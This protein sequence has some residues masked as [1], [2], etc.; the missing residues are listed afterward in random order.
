MERIGIAFYRNDINFMGKPVTFCVIG[1]GDRGRTYASYLADHPQDARLVA[2]AEPRA[3][4]RHDMAA[5]HNIPDQYIFKDWRQVASLEESIADAVI[6]TTQDAMHTTPAL[7][8]IDKGY[9]VLLEKPMAP[10]KQ[11]CQQIVQAAIAKKI[12]FSVCHVLRYTPYTQKIK[13]LLDQGAIGDVVSIQHL[14]PIGYDHF[15]H[16][17]V[18]GHWRNEKES[19][20]MLLAK[21]CHDF[22]WLQYIVGSKI[23]KVSSFGNLKY[24]KVSNKPNGAE[25]HCVDCPI[26]PGCPYS[27]V[28]IYLDRAKAGHIDWPVN[29]ITSD[30]T[31]AGIQSAIRTGPYGRCVYDCDN[32]VVDHQVVNIEFQ[33]GATGVFTVTAFTENTGRKTRIFG[34][35][36]ELYGDGKVINR[37]DFLTDTHET[38]QITLK[39][40][41][42]Q[43]GH[44]GGDSALMESFITAV[45]RRDQ[46]LVLSGPVESL[47]SYV[48]VFAAEEARRKNCVVWI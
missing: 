21:A 36:G 30:V 46:S 11:E 23:T 4:Y 43:S 44:G 18:R 47:E 7:S 14:E 3:F 29:T 32:D 39:E 26:E 8:L 22:D 34:T 33:N 37:Y 5:R 40:G 25:R 41:L 13:S 2:V 28:K 1:A 42:I 15:A 6:I 24:F 16:S 27:A 31:V 19:S 9:D 12:I 17:F 20:F 45:A 38:I 10:T 35:Q 48:P